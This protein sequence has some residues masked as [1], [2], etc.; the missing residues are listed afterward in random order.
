MIEA[1]DL[2]KAYRVK[3]KGH[4]YFGA[5]F[6]PGF[7]TIYALRDVSFRVARGETVGI[8]GPNGAGKTTLIK[9]IAGLLQPSAGLLRIGDLPPREQRRR[10]GI[11]IGSTMS[12]HRMTGYDNLEYFARLYGVADFDRRIWA[13]ADFLGLRQWMD[14]FVEHYSEGTK[15]RLALA[16]ALIHDPDV[17][18]L[19]EPTANL[20]VVASD[21]IHRIIRGLNKTLILTTH[22]LEEARQ[23][24][25]RIL[26]LH[27]GRIARTVDDPKHC[28]IRQLLI[29]ESRKNLRDL[30]G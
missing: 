5:L 7:D 6:S 21:D 23:L 8:V 14:D 11:V 16:R 2:A 25:D 9:I 22:D 15:T 1:C 17:L 27:G 10:I 3:R 19:D 4:G 20:D 30:Q 28:D 18:I 12:F 13:L 24:S 29:D 26:L